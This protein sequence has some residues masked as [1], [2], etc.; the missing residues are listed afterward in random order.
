M[1]S[2]ITLPHIEW[3]HTAIKSLKDKLSRTNAQK[4]DIDMKFTPRRTWQKEWRRHH[5]N[6]IL[7]VVTGPPHG[8]K[9]VV[10]HRATP[11]EESYGVLPHGK[12]SKIK[13]ILFDIRFCYL[14][15]SVGPLVTHQLL[16]RMETGGGGGGG[17]G[18]CVQS[19]LEDVSSCRL[20]GKLSKYA[21][22][23]SVFSR[24]PC[25][26]LVHF[27]ALLTKLLTV[28]LTKRYFA[29]PTFFYFQDMRH[30]TAQSHVLH[31]HTLEVVTTGVSS[32][33]IL[34]FGGYVWELTINS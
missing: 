18:A 16:Y 31:E 11:H 15:K 2:S 33:A 3:Y 22:S 29:H 21:Y 28:S 27:A 5:R 25:W 7:A 30:P 13:G 14:E 10:D 34:V 32:E 12:T 26:I 8:R 20:A 24:S 9:S 1:T 4:L 19:N 17:G 6:A 23:K